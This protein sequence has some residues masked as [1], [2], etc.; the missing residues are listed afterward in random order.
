MFKNVIAILTYSLFCGVATAASPT[1]T[2]TSNLLRNSGFETGTLQHWGWGLNKDAQA[3]AVIDQSVTHSGNFSLRLTNNSQRTPNVF[4]ILRQRISNL[5]PNTRYTLSAW[6]KATATD[7]GWIGGGP[8]WKIRLHYPAGSYDW[9]QISTVFETDESSSFDL[10]IVT[11]GPTKSLWID[12][13][14]VEVATAEFNSINNP[15]F[16]SGNLQPWGWGVNKDAKAKVTIDQTEAHSGNYSLKLTN[17]SN[18][19]PNVFGILRQRISNLKPNTHYTLSAWVKATEAGRGWIGGGPGWKI[20][21]RYPTGSYDWQRISISFE[22][23]DS[24][25]FE[26]AIVTEG[27]TKALWV[28]DVSIQESPEG[29]QA[30]TARLFPP[31]ISKGIP[32]GSRFYPIFPSSNDLSPP[33]VKI[34]SEGQSV[35]G[36]DVSMTSS[37]QGLFFSL[38]VLDSDPFKTANGEMIWNGDSIQIAFDTSG[39]TGE[40][41]NTNTYYEIG[42]AWPGQG[43]VTTYAWVGNFTW[44]GVEATGERTQTGYI[45]NITI[46]WRN[47][48]INPDHLPRDIGINVVVNDL[49]PDGKRRYI[50]WTPSTARTKNAALFARAFFVPQGANKIN[51]IFPSQTTY[52]RDQDIAGRWV[53]YSLGKLPAS[54]L[55]LNIKHGK[56]EIQ[57]TESVYP[58]LAELELSPLAQGYTRQVH[59]WLPATHFTEEGAYEIRTVQKPLAVAATEVSTIATIARTDL[60]TRI[61]AGLSIARERMIKAQNKW[62]HI[63]ETDPYARLRLSIITRF[64]AR[65]E[66]NYKHPELLPWCL[67]QLEELDSILTESE[68][69]SLPT[70]TVQF[71][72]IPK[73][74]SISS[75]GIFRNA[76]SNDPFYFYGY[77][78]FSQ[79]FRD[80]P[81]LSEIGATLIQQEKGPNSLLANG[82]IA[83]YTR[84]FIQDLLSRAESSG[85]KVDFLL[86][87]HYMPGRVFEASPDARLAG[88]SGFA[89]YDID[90]P[91]IRQTIKNWLQEAIPLLKESPALLSVCLANEP[92]YAHSGRT[93]YSRPAWIAYLEKTHDN[94]ERLNTVYSTTYANFDT[95]PV[96]APVRPEG[97]EQQRAWFDWVRFNQQHLAEWIGWMNEEVKSIAPEILTHAKVMANIFKRSYLA[98]GTDPE[99]ICAVTDIAG[100][101]AW[102]YHGGGYAY[103]WQSSQMWYDLLHSFRDQSVFNSENHFIR[104]SSPAT[105][106]PAAHTR[107]VLWQGALHHQGATAMWVWDEPRDR[108][109]SGNISLRPANVWAAGK[110]LLDLRRL[111]PEVAALSSAPARVALLYSVPSI[112]W[113]DTYTPTATT[114]YSALMFS[115][116]PVTFIS[117]KQLATGVR[118]RANEKVDTLI[119]PHATHVSPKAIEGIQKFIADGGRVLA[120]GN[121]NLA[122]NEYGQKHSS[123]LSRVSVKQI[124]VS[125]Q[126]STDNHAVKLVSHALMP[127]FPSE[128]TWQL[129]DALSND[130]AWGVEW[131]I[132]PYQNGHLL[133]MTNMT[134]EPVHVRVKNPLNTEE[135]AHIIDLFTDQPVSTNRFELAPM[136]PYLFFLK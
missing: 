102:A 103:D 4:G 72:P 104:D 58:S 11:E 106:I 28:D 70:E 100:N 105:H 129:C 94:I 67:L 74:V 80:V 128:A 30:D 116:Y 52:D 63:V 95:V 13:I 77:G 8:G 73:Q 36:A 62:C 114:V 40:Q 38:N 83:P 45:L 16:E 127:F 66:K 57:Y 23:G 111:A 86:S 91:A 110:T 43:P 18:Y 89:K 136:E 9:Q 59:F 12:D 84:N 101:D 134:Q 120:I 48:S 15:G 51:V 112:F 115:G 61:V 88:A 41:G 68:T 31:S 97:I 124:P 78:H 65:I 49:G 32:P 69:L 17:D 24:N 27:P 96:P 85:L 47:L 98:Q 76:R 3:T 121:D 133:S 37:P 14:S 125:A 71:S 46:P 53:E 39:A 75:N 35:F 42:F 33:V 93:P 109:T 1:D 122:F 50:E 113:E 126:S 26:L 107:S 34:R 7:R 119:L 135:T 5:K 90:H 81:H 117:E 25:S 87:P 19:T 108:D 132:V 54:Q 55:S 44:A 99:L 22:T 2:S 92:T 131:R 6:I 10:V 29:T 130:A 64:V 79:A 123:E 56:Q 20:R 118:S 60:Q 21:L 82:K